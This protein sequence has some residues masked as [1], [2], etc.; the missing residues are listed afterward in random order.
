[1]KKYV[2]GVVGV[3]L[4][5]GMVWLLFRDTDWGQVREALR[6]ANWPL[7]LVALVPMFL[8]HPARVRRWSFIV[9]AVHAATFS[10]MFS[11]T[12]I[13]FLAN[14]S[15]PARAGEVIRPL[16]LTR[17]TRVPF[18]KAMALNAVDRIT[19]L[20]GLLAVMVVSLIAFRP[21]EGI[22]IPPE[23]FGTDHPI[24]LSATEYQRGAVTTG[25]FLVIVIAAFLAL[26]LRRD[27]AIAISDRT[28]GL[29]SRRVADFINGM[30]H[31][32]ADGLHV[33]RSPLDLA[34]STLWSLGTWG[35]NLLGLALALMAFGIEFPWYTP[36]VMQ[37]I[38][39]I[40]IAAPNTPGFVGPFHI[41]IVL[42]LVMTVP[43]IDVNVAKAY[44]IIAHLWQFPAILIFGFGCLFRDNMNLFEL[45]REGQEQANEEDASGANEAN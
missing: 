16:V 10:Q 14:M 20:F 17:L 42:S 13:G 27:V 15:L 3:V 23:T 45:Q 34:R 24:T 39:S 25:I 29:V 40:A 36:F 12:Q 33:F 11:A 4:M 31:H 21:S 32:F 37:A 19:D 5:V 35:L 30:I 7:L 28:F 9:R 1:V 38:I 44:A 41:A 26:Y 22:S 6:G 43:N 2:F 8:S 18:S